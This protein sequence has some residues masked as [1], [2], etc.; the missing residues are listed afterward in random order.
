MTMQTTARD[1]KNTTAMCDNGATVC[2]LLLIYFRFIL[3]I[4]P[5]MS[6]ILTLR[7]TEL[8]AYYTE[9]Y[10]Y[11]HIETMADMCARDDY[12]AFV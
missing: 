2:L 1:H 4:A 8:P 6:I 12:Q 11:I 9:M 5:I 3:F 10:S 7:H